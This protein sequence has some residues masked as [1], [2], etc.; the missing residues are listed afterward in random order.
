[1]GYTFHCGWMIWWDYPW[2]HILTLPASVSLLSHPEHWSLVLILWLSSPSY[3]LWLLHSYQRLNSTLVS[4]TGGRRG[5]TW[6]RAS[7]K[8]K[9][10]V[11]SPQ[12]YP[13]QLL[14]RVGHWY[15][16][17]RS[18]SPPLAAFRGL[19][20]EEASWRGVCPISNPSFL[21]CFCG[22]AWHQHLSS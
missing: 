16:V 13:W 7:S 8:D 20:W 5:K 22:S 11:Y 19:M 2:Q 21:A 15:A 1:M 17:L 6:N 12:A 3:L 10:M 14:T 18:S 4:N 9:K